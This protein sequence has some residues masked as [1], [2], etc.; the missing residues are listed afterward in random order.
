M[1]SETKTRFVG[2]TI[3][4]KANTRGHFDYGWLKTYHTFSF[5]N[6]YDPERVNFGMLRVLNDDTIEAGEGFGT[7]P[8][9][10]MEIVTIPLE[11]A[12]AHKDSTGGE[13]VIYPDEI[14]VMSAGTG[15]HHSEY[16]HLNDGTT[17][18]LQL[19]IFP[20]KKGH[21]PRYNQKF[22]NSEERKNKLQFIVTPEKKGDNLWLNQDAYLALSDLEKSKSLNYK[23]H[24]KG[25]G[26]YLF[27]IDGNISVGDDKL[28]K[29]D[30]IGLWET[31][32]I[33]I[34]ASEDSRLLFIEVPMM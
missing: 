6:Y 5:S 19:W 18:L 11:G 3:I 13:G 17:K 30:G 32:E 25:N 12:V 8:H 10:D 21:E 34:N 2:K 23:I 29:R 26:V 31:E 7:H 9:N 16:N 1:L 20:D 22:F 24:T 27:L 33:S 15:I 14:Q 28:F 4:H